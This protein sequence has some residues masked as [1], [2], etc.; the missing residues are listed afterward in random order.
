LRVR[1]GA[2]GVDGKHGLLRAEQ[3]S[4]KSYRTK[5]TLWGITSWKITPSG[6]EPGFCPLALS[7]AA[8]P[9]AQQ[10]FL[11]LWFLRV[12]AFRRLPR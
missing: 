12:T 1:L 8:R 9:C 11:A 10:G 6:C 4:A 5:L 2:G 7:P 3:K